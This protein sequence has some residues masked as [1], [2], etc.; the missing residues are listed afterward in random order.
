MSAAWRVVEIKSSQP[1]KA[2][3]LRAKSE[4]KILRFAQNDRKFVKKKK[5]GVTPLRKANSPA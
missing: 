3:I 1:V 4:E 2:V 5:G